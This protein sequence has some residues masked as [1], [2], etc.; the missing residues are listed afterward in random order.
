[1]RRQLLSGGAAGGDTEAAG[2]L[3]QM[4]VDGVLRQAQPPPDFLGGEVLID[5]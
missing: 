4:V 1:V 3:G 5:Q 2:R